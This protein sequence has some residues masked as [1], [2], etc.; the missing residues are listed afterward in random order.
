MT[1]EAIT[2][3]EAKQANTAMENKEILRRESF[4]LNEDDHYYEL[5]PA[6]S[7]HTRITKQAV[8]RALFSQSVKKAPCPDKLSLSAIWLLRKWDKQRIV[9]LTRSAIHTG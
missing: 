7:A 6:G 8:E 2:D 5:P 1:V 4:P 3:R 9:G